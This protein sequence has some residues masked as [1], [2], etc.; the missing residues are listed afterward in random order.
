MS[1]WD[2]IVSGIIATAIGGELSQSLADMSRDDVQKAYALLRSKGRITGTSYVAADFEHH[3]NKRGRHA[4]RNPLDGIAIAGYAHLD[5]LAAL[6]RVSEALPK[7]RSASLMSP[8]ALED[9]ELV[10]AAN[11]L[12]SS[13]D[14]LYD[15][16]SS[17]DFAPFKEGM[18]SAGT[19]YIGSIPTKMAIGIQKHQLCRMVA[20]AVNELVVKPVRDSFPSWP[21]MSS[22]LEYSARD[23]Q[24]I[25]NVLLSGYDELSFAD[26]NV[27]RVANWRVSAFDR[28]AILPSDSEKICANTKCMTKI[29]E[30]YELWQH[31]LSVSGHSDIFAAVGLEPSP[32]IARNPVKICTLLSTFGEMSGIDSM[33][34]ALSAGVPVEDITS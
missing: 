5:C 15:V 17:N 30:A 9:K 12:L 27:P 22:L 1:G 10:S 11:V 28:V 18:L 34:D 7:G 16:R 20:S 31:A 14:L 2:S 33:F 29:E 13:L 26:K 32:D 25:A 21:P 19:A 6:G 4:G 23:A 3:G 24:D 8:V